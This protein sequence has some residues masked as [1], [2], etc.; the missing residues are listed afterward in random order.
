M[1]AAAAATLHYCGGE[2]L[3]QLLLSGTRGDG[4]G[5]RNNTV[6]LLLR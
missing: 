5:G 4:D 6:S 1:I 3:G 2:F